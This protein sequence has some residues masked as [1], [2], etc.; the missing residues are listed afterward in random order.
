ML[1]YYVDMNGKSYTI[2]ELYSLFYGVDSAKKT[3]TKTNLSLGADA[4]ANED[5]VIICYEMA[6]VD[7]NTI[8]IKAEKNELSVKADKI[9]PNVQGYNVLRNDIVYGKC[10][11]SFTIGSEY[12]LENLQAN[13][14]NGMLQIR[15]PRKPETK[16]KTFKIN[17]VQKQLKE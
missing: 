1:N 16:P 4:Y 2:P 10:Y 5:E 13:Y 3:L 14:D 11:R 12:D 17:T 9:A 15:I 6:G 8:E 7:A